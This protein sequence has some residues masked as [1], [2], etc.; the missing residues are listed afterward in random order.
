MDRVE[1]RVRMSD[2]IDPLGD[3]PIYHPPP[4]NEILPRSLSPQYATIRPN[5]RIISPDLQV[6]INDEEET[7]L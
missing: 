1:E 3:G 6:P 5:R 7:T 2:I 4:T